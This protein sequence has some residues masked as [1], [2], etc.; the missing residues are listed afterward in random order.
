MSTETGI[1]YAVAA[2]RNLER[3]KEWIRKARDH[4]EAGR[5][6]AACRSAKW[7][8]DW[9]HDYLSCLRR[10]REFTAAATSGV[11]HG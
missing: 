9:M 1:K 5:R 11:N 10:A 3:A 4:R 6:D 7:A 2:G 8:R